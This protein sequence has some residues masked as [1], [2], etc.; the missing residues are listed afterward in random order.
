[1]PPSPRLL[2]APLVALLLAGCHYYDDDYP[3]YA[4]GSLKSYYYSSDG[5][6]L[7]TAILSQPDIK[8]VADE[9]APV[10]IRAEITREVVNWSASEGKWVPGGL[11]TDQFTY[12]YQGGVVKTLSAPNSSALPADFTLK[13]TKS[14]TLDVLNADDGLRVFTC[15][16]NDHAAT[17]DATNPLH[18]ASF[19][20]AKGRLL[21]AATDCTAKAGDAVT[22][23]SKSGVLIE[24]PGDAAAKT[25]LAARMGNS[26]YSEYLVFDKYRA[27]I[28]WLPASTKFCEGRAECN[29]AGYS[30]R[31]E[32]M[33]A[34]AAEVEKAYSKDAAVDP[35]K[36]GLEVSKTL[37][38]S[39]ELAACKLAFGGSS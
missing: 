27:P 25:R 19:N 26:S 35:W 7:L 21:E 18:A 37:K 36:K 24:I 9:V 33:S 6:H 30:A 16:M 34:C 20:A 39:A 32:S 38:K 5:E 2:S 29:A 4:W 14:I 12:R 11:K 1:M 10:T 31:A 15:A 17:L 28:Q 3:D 8:A 22:H 23:K 13:T